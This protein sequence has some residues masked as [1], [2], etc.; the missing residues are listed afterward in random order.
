MLGAFASF[1]GLSYAAERVDHGVNAV[2][3]VLTPS[4]EPGRRV[5]QRSPAADEYGS[6]PP[7]T[8]PPGGGV[9]AGGGG[10]GAAGPPQAQVSGELPFTGFPL[11]VTAGIGLGLVGVGAVLR[12]RER[13][14]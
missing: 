11:I 8:P 7:T 4:S 3:T 13:R 10:G 12:R 5:A 9:S 14:S 2:K 1:G 6:P